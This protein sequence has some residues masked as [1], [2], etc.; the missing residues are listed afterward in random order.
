MFDFVIPKSRRSSERLLQLANTP[1]KDKVTALMFKW[2]D[3]RE[4]RG[5][6]VKSYVIL[7]DEE[8]AVPQTAIGAFLSYD[9]TPIPWSERKKFINALAA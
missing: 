5:I 2:A 7:N 4:T 9:S 3:A 8:S 1:D 6:E